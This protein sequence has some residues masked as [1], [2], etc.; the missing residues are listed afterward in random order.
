MQL[1]I[2]TVEVNAPID[3]YRQKVWGLTETI[4]SFPEGVFEDLINWSPNS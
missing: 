2:R 4:D 1:G 3:F